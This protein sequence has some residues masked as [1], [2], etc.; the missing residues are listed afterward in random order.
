MKIAIAFLAGVAT[1]WVA[2]YTLAK[3]LNELSDEEARQY[4]FSEEMTV[5]LRESRRVGEL[6]E[7]APVTWVTQELTKDYMGSRR[8]TPSADPDN[9]SGTYN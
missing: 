2:L 7:V 1:A 3:A 8:L 4:G 6:V 5:G 9:C